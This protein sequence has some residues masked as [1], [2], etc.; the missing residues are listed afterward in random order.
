MKDTKKNEET[1][2]GV[3]PEF[4]RLPRNGTRCPWSG[5]SRTAINNLVL[6][7]VTNDHKPPVKSISLRT[8]GAS[9]GTRLI[10]YDSLMGYL[11][12]KIERHFYEDGE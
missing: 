1:Y 7:C 4:I 12:S 10:V 11:R 2:E 5:L 3:R 6:P 8:R 9:R